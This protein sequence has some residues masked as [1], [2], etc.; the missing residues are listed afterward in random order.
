MFFHQESA[1]IGW[2]KVDS[3]PG[4]VGEAETYQD[5]ASNEAHDYWENDG[6]GTLATQGSGELSTGTEGSAEMYSL[7]GTEVTYN[8]TVIN[9]NKSTGGNLSYAVTS[10]TARARIG[11]HTGDPRVSDLEVSSSWSFS[12]WYQQDYTGST[13]SNQ[14]EFEFRDSSSSWVR[15][16]ILFVSNSGGNQTVKMSI[17]VNGGADIGSG[18]TVA[19]GTAADEDIHHV[20]YAYDSGTNTHTLWV[21]GTIVDTQNPSLGGRRYSGDLI[22][23]N[24]A[25][26]GSGT[27]EW[28][29][30]DVEFVTGAF[31]ATDISNRYSFSG[32][33]GESD[34]M[35]GQS[36]GAPL[37]ITTGSL[38]NFNGVGT[39]SDDLFA[40]GHDF[41][42]THSFSHTHQFTGLEHGGFAAEKL[43]TPTGSGAS[44]FANDDGVNIATEPSTGGSPNTTTTENADSNTSSTNPSVDESTIKYY[45]V[46]LCEKD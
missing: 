7:T 12:M 18:S 31:D 11:T 27:R 46:I 28:R 21:D 35:T 39:G 29:H 9:P 33:T 23:Q 1:P 38:V 36:V 5:Q 4:A 24:Y 34:Y 3:T 26:S 15:T 41:S 6:S 17:D 30:S 10:G 16:E 44:V 8:A 14:F 43:V 19:I 40:H 22:W 2:T 37:V 20:A 13:W 42:H 25:V 45:K 32:G